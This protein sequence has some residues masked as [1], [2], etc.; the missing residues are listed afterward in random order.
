MPIVRFKGS[1]ALIQQDLLFGL[2][3]LEPVGA[4]NEEGMGDEKEAD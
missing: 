1:S 2:Q 3:M 4:Q